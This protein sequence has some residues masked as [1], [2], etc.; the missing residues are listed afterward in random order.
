MFLLLCFGGWLDLLYGGWLMCWFSL[1]GGCCDWCDGLVCVVAV[2]IGVMV[3][4]VGSYGWCGD[5]LM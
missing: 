1:C 2:A 5:W 3:L 4:V